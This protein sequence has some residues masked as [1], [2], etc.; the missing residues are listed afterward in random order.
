M[1]RKI[2]TACVLISAAATAAG[3]NFGETSFDSVTGRFNN[4]DIVTMRVV[5]NSENGQLV[6]KSE[7]GSL[8][9]L[10]ADVPFGYP[11]LTTL[12]DYF[13]GYKTTAIVFG[14]EEGLLPSDMMRYYYLRDGR[15]NEGWPD[16]TELMPFDECMR[17][18]R[19]A[20]VDVQTVK[21]SVKGYP[22]TYALFPAAHPGQRPTGKEG[23]VSGNDVRYTRWLV[24]GK[25][26]GPGGV[27][28]VRSEVTEDSP[29]ARLI[30]E[31]DLDGDG[32][33]EISLCYTPIKGPAGM[34]VYRIES[35]YGEED[36]PISMNDDGLYA[37]LIQVASTL[38]RSVEAEDVATPLGRGTFS[39]KKYDRSTG[40][41]KTKTVKVIKAFE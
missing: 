30:A 40:R 11:Y 31:G 41:V 26:E 9:T 12:E 18:W 3:Q 36:T 7:D 10:Y 38:L 34:I 8:P 24:A 23:Y 14:I 16:D 29:G 6:L 19:E 5:S 21:G 13:D 27:S 1:R 2:Y 35:P 28:E 15:W 20:G 17:K 37:D 25:V 32:V 33:D 22:V 39:F 4:S